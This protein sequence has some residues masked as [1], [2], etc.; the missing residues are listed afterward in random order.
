MKKFIGRIFV[1]VLAVVLALT[2]T[3][4]KK[5][6][7]VVRVGIHA[8]EG[9]ATLFA[10]AQK[11]GYFE[12]QGL[13]IELT[14]VESGPAEMTAMRASN[15]T[16]D[17]G[18][19]G[20]GVAWNALDDS[21]NRLQ[22]VYLDTLSISEALIADPAKKNV[23]SE[24]S[25]TEL[26]EALKGSTVAIQVDAT[27]GTWFKN[28][29]A[30]VNAEAGVPDAQKL[31]IYC[32]VDAYLADYTAPNTNPAY[33]VTVV[34]ESNENLPQSYQAHEYDFYC[35]FAP[36][37]LS[38]INAGGVQVANTATHLPEFTFPS[39][40]V[41]SVAWMQENPAVVQKFINAL[42]KA[43]KYRAEHIEQSLRWAEEIC[44]VNE[45]TFKADVM[46]A[47]SADE[48]YDWF[49]DFDGRGYTYMKALYDSKVGNVPAGNRVKTLPE[50]MNFSYMLK[51]L[52]EVVSK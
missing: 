48:L 40:W 39:T 44:Q 5:D 37:T 36:S 6:E 23:D 28:F 20:A 15:R 25:W 7:N 14:I 16:L 9:G 41:A 32:E 38:I 45:G 47:P 17:I 35:G 21:G 46:I 19:I 2:L 1:F 27:P 52:S 3:A 22:F 50:T 26:Y 31:W 34:N 12:E 11:M 10:V 30:K 24:S 29:L 13:T 33:K 42:A 18:Y 4:C 51:A 49:K 8:N 43:S